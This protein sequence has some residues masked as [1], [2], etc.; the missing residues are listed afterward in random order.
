MFFGLK[1]RFLGHRPLFGGL[2]TPKFSDKNR[3][4]GCPG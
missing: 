1:K 2:Q 3:A 4:I